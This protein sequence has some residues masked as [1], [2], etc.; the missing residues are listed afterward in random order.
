[1]AIR[2]GGRDTFSMRK[3]IGFIIGGVIGLGCYQIDAW[4]TEPIG[5]AEMQEVDVSDDYLEQ[6]HIEVPID[7]KNA[8]EE[9]GLKYNIAPELLEAICWKESR[10][11]PEVKNGWCKGLMQVNEKVHRKRIKRLGVEDIHDINGNIQTGA[12]YLATLMEINGDLV[13]SLNEYSGNKTSKDTDY[14]QEVIEIAS[15][16]DKGGLD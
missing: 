13:T 15:A 3:I 11:K 8:C 6:K 5:Y 9:N 4:A 12:D 10:F 2:A 16:L 7:V 1:M 14:S